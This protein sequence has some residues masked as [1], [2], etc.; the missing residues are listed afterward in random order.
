[1]PN[2]SPAFIEDY[3]N[4]HAEDDGIYDFPYDEIDRRLEGQEEPEHERPSDQTLV[5]EAL[6]RILIALIDGPLEHEDYQKAVHR[7][8]LRMRTLAGANCQP[9]DEEWLRAQV[10]TPE[11]ARMLQKALKQVADICLRD[12]AGK[13]IPDHLIGRQPKITTIAKQVVALAWLGGPAALNGRTVHQLAEEFGIHKN[14]MSLY[15]SGMSRLLGN[16]RIHAQSKAWNFK[17]EKNARN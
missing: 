12:R 11:Q 8:F 1:M 7:R 10:D 16:Y 15:T 17:A 9:A 13:P 2:G 3:V 5:A 14:S 6:L 4:P